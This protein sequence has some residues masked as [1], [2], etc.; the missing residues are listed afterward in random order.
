MVKVPDQTGSKEMSSNEEITAMK[1]DVAALKTCFEAMMLKIDQVLNSNTSI[2]AEFAVMKT[3][4]NV[5]KKDLVFELNK[6]SCKVD[7]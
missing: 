6:V 7:G 1:R 3:C 4:I 5:M 2:S